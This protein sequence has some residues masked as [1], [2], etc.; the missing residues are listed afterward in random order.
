MLSSVGCSGG[1]S[2]SYITQ[3]QEKMLKSIDT[4]NDGA[5]TKEE[6][7]TNRPDEISEDQAS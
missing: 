3:I 7:V 2:S 1:M 6:L 5:V 4:N